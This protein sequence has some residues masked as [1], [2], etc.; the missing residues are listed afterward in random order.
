MN[1]WRNDPHAIERNKQCR[2]PCESVSSFL[3]RGHFSN[4]ENTFQIFDEPDFVVQ[5]TA[6]IL[7]IIIK[8]V[9]TSIMKVGGGE[10]GVKVV[11]R[12]VTLDA[13]LE[14]QCHLLLSE[15]FPVNRLEK[16][17]L[18]ELGS[19]S[20]CAEAVP[21]IPIEQLH[22]QRSHDQLNDPWR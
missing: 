16:G 7:V 15:S 1:E 17:M 8:D 18:F 10:L 6:V 12:L 20:L 21:W 2:P 11:C 3:Y 13:G 22:S 5:C 14:R 9:N 4:Y 19:V